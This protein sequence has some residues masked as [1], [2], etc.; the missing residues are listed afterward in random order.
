[1]RFTHLLKCCRIGAVRREHYCFHGDLRGSWVER[2]GPDFQK[3]GNTLGLPREK[4]RNREKV[5]ER[6]VRRDKLNLRVTHLA[7]CCAVAAAE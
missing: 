4:P 2:W 6:I 3:S 5:R 1:M 7:F